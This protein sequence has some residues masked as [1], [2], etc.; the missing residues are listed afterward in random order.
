MTGDELAARLY[1]EQGYLVVSHD[2]EWPIEHVFAP[3]GYPRCGIPMRIIGPSNRQEC[4]SQCERAA[5]LFGSPLPP[6]RTHKY[7]YRVEAAD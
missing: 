7:F 5:K 3:R 1:A 4:E 6:P 2:Q